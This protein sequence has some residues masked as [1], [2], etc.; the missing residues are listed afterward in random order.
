MLQYNEVYQEWLICLMVR[1]AAGEARTTVYADSMT[2]TMTPAGTRRVI[3]MGGHAAFTRR[4]TAVCSAAGGKGSCVPR[5][6][7]LSPPDRSAVQ[8]AVL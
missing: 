1:T 6:W 2:V 8:T 4:M 5:P 7:T 3:C